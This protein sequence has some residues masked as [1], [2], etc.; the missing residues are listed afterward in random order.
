MA[1]DDEDQYLSYTAS[2]ITQGKH[3]FYTLTIPSD[4]LA[5]TCFV[6][7]R[8]EDPVE[9]FQRLL[10]KDR[11]QEIADYIDAGFGTIPTS[12]VLSAQDIAEFT[13][14]SAKRTVRFRY[15]P[16]AFLILDGQ[17]RIYGFH[18]A[19]SELR[20]PVVIYN[21]LA[22]RDESRLFIDINTKQRAV[23]NE[24][25]LDI[26]KIADYR[27]DVESRLGDI[28]DLFASE[29]TSPLLGSMSA[30]RR[31]KDYISRVTFNS[32]TK[33]ILSLFGD[34]DIQ[35]IYQILSAYLTS[36]LSTAKQSK[37]EI[38]ITAPIVF[39]A[40]MS[41]FPEIAQRVR[42]KHGVVYTTDNFA[43]VIASMLK[44]VKHSSVKN[45]GNSVTSYAKVFTD[46]MKTKSIF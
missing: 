24:L 44:N 3:R 22:R 32:A 46:A 45:V 14:S 4:V 9:G 6:I 21:D 30:S 42:D 35:D 20:V 11:A 1:T 8:D 31:R 7:D 40:L 38:N 36:F 43:E 39:R 10:N 18:L 15:N 2:L 41:I 27:N 33:P 19:K 12:I 26:R 16:K 23:P 17:H 37:L 28:F 34:A 29:P 13:Y 5:R 25:L